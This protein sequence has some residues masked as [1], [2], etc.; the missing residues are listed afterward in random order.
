MKGF[1]LSYQKNL[2]L[3]V[4]IEDE[5]FEKNNCTLKKLLGEMRDKLEKGIIPP[6]KKGQKCSGCSM[7]DLCMPS[8]KQIKKVRALVN[9]I[10]QTEM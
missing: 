4:V 3:V 6:I 2:A 8:L 1:Q 10:S 7:K 5:D 9:T